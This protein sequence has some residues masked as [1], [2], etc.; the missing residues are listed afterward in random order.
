[1]PKQVLNNNVHVWQ[2]NISQTKH[3]YNYFHNLLS[4]DEKIKAARFK[5]EKDKIA[6]VLARG[7]LRHLLSKYLDCPATNIIFHYNKYGKP[8]LTNNKTIKFNVSHAGEVVVIAFIE[9]N[10]IGIDVEHIKYNFN[11]FDVVDSYFSKT[12]IE[13][14]HKLPENLQTEAF[15]RGWT[16]KEAFIKAKAKGLSFPLDSFS[17]SMDS[18][19]KAELIE[20][21]WDPEE[22][23]LWQIIPFKTEA[24]YKAALAVKSVNA[25]IEHFEFKP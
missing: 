5:F 1:M 13:A 25:T 2:F 9:N 23:K 19:E 14:L 22:K 11:V 21:L 8:Q 7:A 17:I 18:D 10:D 24:N 12:E 3:R 4:K 20:T 6:S 16:R 15:F